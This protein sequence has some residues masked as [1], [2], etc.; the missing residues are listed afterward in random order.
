MLQETRFNKHFEFY[1][2]MNK[3]F[4]I[5]SGC[6]TALPFDKASQNNDKNSSGGCC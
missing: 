1:G 5:F 2:N 4:G 3:H 6:G